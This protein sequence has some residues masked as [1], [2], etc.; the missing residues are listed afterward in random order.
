MN[1]LVGIHDV[2]PRGQTRGRTSDP[3]NGQA[4]YA[5]QAYSSGAPL[6]YGP[7]RRTRRDYSFIRVLT[8]AAIVAWLL[9][10]Y[11]PTVLADVGHLLGTV[12]AVFTQGVPTP[13][14][15]GSDTSYVTNDTAPTDIGAQEP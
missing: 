15:S 8:A 4:G 6:R 14:A 10:G 3:D 11:A 2:R 7:Y 5:H 1:D 13:G 12:P 9:V